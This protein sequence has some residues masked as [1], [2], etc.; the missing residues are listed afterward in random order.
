M[1]GWLVKQ[2]YYKAEGKEASLLKNIHCYS[3][4]NEME[5]IHLIWYSWLRWQIKEIIY[6]G[7]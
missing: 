5:N 1:C 7:H 4:L 6:S 3:W 2:P